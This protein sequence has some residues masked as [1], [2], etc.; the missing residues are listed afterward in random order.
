MSNLSQF[1]ADQQENNKPKHTAKIKGPRSIGTTDDDEGRRGLHRHHEDD[2]DG[3]L[4]QME[5]EGFRDD[6]KA[7]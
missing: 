4:D 2:E 7:V 6:R 1:F 5:E 3:R